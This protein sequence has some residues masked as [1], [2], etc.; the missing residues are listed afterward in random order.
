MTKKNKK[1]LYT[2]I[3]IVAALFYTILLASCGPSKEEIEWREKCIKDSIE[4]FKNSFVSSELLYIKAHHM[5]VIKLD[6][7][8]YWVGD[9]IFEHKGNC[10]NLVHNTKE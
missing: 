7:C 1:K 2:I 3:F 4:A 6:S 10:S 9:N 5:Q 8:E